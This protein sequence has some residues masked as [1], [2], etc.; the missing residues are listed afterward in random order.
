MRRLVFL[1]I[2]LSAVGLQA[3]TYYGNGYTIVEGLDGNSMDLNTPVYKTITATSIG[4]GLTQLLDGSGWTLAAESNAD[5]A[6]WRLYNQPY[7]EY[8]RT[9][10]P[11]PL[12]KALEY[13]SGDA[14]DLVVDPVNRLISYEVNQRY[15]T[16]LAPTLNTPS[17]YPTATETEFP[18]TV[19]SLAGEISNATS[20][21]TRSLKERRLDSS[22]S[23]VS[24][25]SPGQSS[26]NKH[27]VH[28]VQAET[29]TDQT[30]A[31]ES[32]DMGIFLRNVQSKG[33]SR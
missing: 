9:L 4:S 14:W 11:I 22:L 15:H 3:Q 10:N 31:Q 21:D 6:I 30:S 32:F 23:Q 13:L 25:F 7:P 26:S 20:K 12:G 27:S 18:A 28:S 8:K 24:S 5:P 1:P 19:F 29:I 2:L 33:G 17:L 16:V